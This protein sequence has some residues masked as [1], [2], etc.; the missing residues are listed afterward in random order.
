RPDAVNLAVGLFFTDGYW[1][2]SSYSFANPAV[3]VARSFTD[4]FAGIAPAH[5]PAFIA[6]EL[7]GAVAATLLFRWLERNAAEHADPS[8]RQE[9]P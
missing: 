7:A 8:V 1:F 9:L 5:A 3:T 2:Y 4:T 6:A